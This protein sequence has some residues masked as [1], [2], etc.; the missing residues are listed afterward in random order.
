MRYWFDTEFIDDTH[1]I[2][3]ISIGFVN[4]RNETYYAVSSEFDL[5]TA[6]ADSWLNANVL[7][8]LPPQNEWKPRQLIRKEITAFLGN[9][10]EFWVYNGAYDWVT[11]C[12]LFGSI[13]DLP[14]QYPWYA[15]DIKQLAHMLHKP[16]LPEQQENTKHNALEDAK[17]NKLVWE[18]LM[19]S[20]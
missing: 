14:R 19:K 20:D 5:R 10:P 15:N 12:Q 1:T 17:W 4:E 16:I 3:L 6:Q 9:N 11:F 2:D 13:R 7:S 18:L 8:H